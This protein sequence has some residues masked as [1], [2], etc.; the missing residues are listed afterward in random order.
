MPTARS[1]LTE[2]PW[3]A[4]RGGARVGRETALPCAVESR[5]PVPEGGPFSIA[6]FTRGIWR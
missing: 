4:A 6:S 1:L 2:L 3:K 5:A